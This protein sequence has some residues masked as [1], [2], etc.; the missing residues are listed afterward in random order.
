M[1]GEPMADWNLMFET[2]QKI[3]QTST[4]FKD[5]YE[6][7]LRFAQQNPE[8]YDNQDYWQKAATTEIP[9]NTLLSW[10]KEGL[11][12]LQPFDKWSLILL[13]CGDAPDIFR[14]SE[15]HLSNETSIDTF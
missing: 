7:I 2:V 10:V 4:D 1:K 11:E 12:N 9:I 14:M 15:I 13:D 8:E 3:V 5:G 6:N